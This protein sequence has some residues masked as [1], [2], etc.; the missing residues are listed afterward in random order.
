MAQPR[1]AARMAFWFDLK[2]FGMEKV[3]GMKTRKHNLGDLGY[4]QN[5]SDLSVRGCKCLVKDKFSKKLKLVEL[6]ARK[7]YAFR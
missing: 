5:T 7:R 3:C 6:E 1:A 2:V 4:R